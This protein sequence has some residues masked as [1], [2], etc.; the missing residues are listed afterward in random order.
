MFHSLKIV[1]LMK[2]R[3]FYARREYCVQGG[4]AVSRRNEGFLHSMTETSYFIFYIFVHRTAAQ[5]LVRNR[6]RQIT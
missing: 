6:I 1:I 5:A 4:A 3:N 2:S